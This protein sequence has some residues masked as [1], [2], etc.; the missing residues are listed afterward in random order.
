[1]VVTAAIGTLALSH[2]AVIAPVAKGAYN[3]I[4]GILLDTK[5]LMRRKGMYRRFHTIHYKNLIIDLIKEWIWVKKINIYKI[6]EII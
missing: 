3:K 6:S 5:L 4:Y 1:M 2:A